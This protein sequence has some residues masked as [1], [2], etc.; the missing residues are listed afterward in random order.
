MKK[1]VFIHIGF[2]KTGSSAIQ[3]YF[4]SNR[5]ELASSE[6][7][8]PLPFDEKLNSH[9]ELAWV[10]MKKGKYDKDAVFS[11]YRNKIENSDKG[12]VFISSEDLSLLR[13]GNVSLL[14]SMLEGF[15]V[16]ILVYIRDPLDYMLSMYHHKVRMATEDR[17]FR[18]YLADEKTRIVNYKLRLT[19]WVRNF[20]EDNIIKRAYLPAKFVGGNIA[21]D[22]FNSIGLDLG[23]KDM[24]KRVNV[25]VHPWLVAAYQ[26]L[27]E[28]ND[29][30][31][32][33]LDMHRRNM[34]EVSLL[35]P[36]IDAANYYLGEENAAIIRRVLVESNRDILDQIGYSSE[37]E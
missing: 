23:F 30:S 10:F 18:E 13:G 27:G 31:G 3:N 34:R 2:Q 4:N 11:Y 36:K 21:T 28:V 24:P 12:N 6:V 32:K 33:E 9:Q 8:Y 15:N 5:Q 29:L 20:G 7:D 19:P 17:P 25:G 22:V 14:K 26:K 16:K 37:H 35:L 1:N